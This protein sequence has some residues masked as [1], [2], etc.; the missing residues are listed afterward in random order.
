MSLYGALFTGVSGLNTQG[1][2]IGIISDNIANV[3]TVGYK[4]A[5]AQFQSLVVNAS[6]VTSFSPGG[7]RATTRY[8]IDQQGQLASTSAPTDIAIS[9]Q[10][11]FVV[12]ALSDGSGQTLF[13]RAGSFRQDEGGNFINSQGFFLQA[14]PLDREGR[15]PGEVGNTNTTS[16][17]NVESL[18]TVNVESVVGTAEATE[19]VEIGLNLD[20]DEAIFAGEGATILMDAFAPNNFEIGAEDIIAPDETSATVPPP[21]LGLSTTN[22]IARGDQFTVSTGSGFSYD[23][24]YGGF[25][26]SRDI[27][28]GT[29]ANMGD[30][31]IITT[32]VAIPAGAISTVDT[33]T[34][35]RVNFA[36]IFAAGAVA[37]LGLV[38]GDQ[39][40]LAGV[41]LAA[42]S[43][44]PTAELAGIHTITNI[45]G[46]IVEFQ[47]TTTETAGA[48]QLNLATGTIGAVTDTAGNP[49]AMRL[50]T[51]NIL[52]ANSATTSLISPGTLSDY[53]VNAR[54]FT[55]TTQT[56]GQATFTYVS[57]S[58]SPT[59]GTFNN[60]ISLA[61]AINANPFLTARVVDGRLLAGAVDATESV[62]FANVDAA[63]DATGLGIDWLT[64]LGLTDV[65]AAPRRFSNMRGL[66][67][68]VNADEGISAVLNDSS[69]VA[70]LQIHVDDPLDTIEFED[71]L[72]PVQAMAAGTV[73]VNAAAASPALD[74]IRITYPGHGLAVGSNVVLQNFSAFGAVLASEI[75]GTFAVT[76]IVDAN[77]FDIQVDTTG[78]AAD[79]NTDGEILFTNVGSLL[80]EFGLTDDDDTLLVPSLL[81]GAYVR[82]DTGALGPK[83]DASGIIGSNMASG[84]IPPHFST[85]VRIFD[86]LGAGHDVV[87]AYLKTALNTWAVE[88]YSNPEGDVS[89]ALT[90]GQLATGTI[91]F[92][93]DGSLA[94]ISTELANPITI[95]WTNGSATSEIRLDL[96]TAGLP[97][98]T[99]GAFA[100]GDT[101]GLQ[102]FSG[103]YKVNFSNQDG[104][105]V[106]ELVGV[107]IDAEGFVIAAYTNGENQ[108]LFKIP[109]ADFTNPNGLRPISGNVYAETV[110]SGDL[111]L[112]EA[113][114]S[115]VG[116]VVS[117]SLEQS[118]VD[119]AEELTDMIVAQRAYQ[120]NTR[121][122]S[123]TDELLEQLNQL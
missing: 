73:V 29:A 33:T 65:A 108:R 21:S 102:Q 16:F 46:D 47:V 95:N 88:V 80:A 105:P 117:A 17:S 24:L 107:E 77:T 31:T 19:N 6:S 10:G 115:G 53:T 32:P 14:W 50:F 12:T 28:I 52:D 122:I 34:T 68:L 94:S 85:S 121:V 5:Q 60:L 58:P 114:E 81:G 63:G 20:A 98:G 42:A 74:T 78:A 118:N 86:A 75:N 56:G 2:K 45:A 48:N 110:D 9:G 109:I 66:A 43:T 83:Y 70:S 3:N 123:T 39:I 72:G 84:D 37:A 89:T 101:D 59:G 54:S 91:T 18:Q 111:I 40:R 15:L 112:R 97:F 49:L 41:S 62:T 119:L 25:T 8:N 26:V 44:I 13:T 11:L 38:N 76:N 35:I 113:G 36:A 82:G 93:G 92:N 96:G 57:S 103:Q 64:E 27:D 55:I 61:A 1:Q 69:T 51:G 7:V 30:S 71:F 116:S 23:Y 106:G 99:V 120:S 67:S 100:I 90:D 22:N 4:K 79:A 104:N 87:F